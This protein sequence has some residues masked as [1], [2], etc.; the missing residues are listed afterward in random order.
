VPTERAEPGPLARVVNV[1]AASP[2]RDQPGARIEDDAALVAVVRRERL[3]QALD[4]TA[5]S[6]SLRLA[7]AALVL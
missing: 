7:R 3:A 6:R 4:G 5:A 1:L 2:G